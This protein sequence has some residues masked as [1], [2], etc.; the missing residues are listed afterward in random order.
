[1]LFQS[2]FA[3]VPADR[4]LLPLKIPFDRKARSVLMPQLVDVHR[5]RERVDRVQ[6]AITAARVLGFM[7]DYPKRCRRGS[8]RCYRSGLQAAGQRATLATGGNKSGKAEASPG[9]QPRFEEEMAVQRYYS[10]SQMDITVH[11]CTKKKNEASLYS[12]CD[13]WTPKTQYRP[14]SSEICDSICVST[15]QVACASVLHEIKMLIHLHSRAERKSDS[16]LVNTLDS[17]SISH[18]GPARQWLSSMSAEGFIEVLY[19]N[20]TVNSQRQ[21]AQADGSV[22]VGRCYLPEME[23][24]PI[25]A[26]VGARACVTQGNCTSLMVA[27]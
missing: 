9:N 11:I 17:E 3:W 24:P 16:G 4:H 22:T 26:Y 20:S 21:H 2:L 1:M 18:W 23:N 15:P 8:F 13:H 6:S 10:R 5:R 19:T 25:S 14:W 7:A 27:V 12:S